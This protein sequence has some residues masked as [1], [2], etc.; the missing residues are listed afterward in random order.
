VE[1]M[2]AISDGGLPGWRIFTLP[3]GIRDKGSFFGAVRE[4]LPLDP[5]LGTG[6][7]W[8]AVADSVWGGLDALADR[9]VAIVWPASFRMALVAPEDFEQA[10]EMFAG[11]AR[12]LSDPEDTA[13]E[14][15]VLAVLL[16]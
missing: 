15:T 12:S 1:L 2:K 16:Q 4:T 6:H 9:R 3:E 11:V 8:E 7:K 13:G 5:P 14:P 10:R